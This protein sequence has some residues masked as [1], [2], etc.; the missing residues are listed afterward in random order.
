MKTLPHPSPDRPAVV[1]A[2]DVPRCLAMVR[3]APRIVVP[4][5]TP[6]E[7][8]HAPFKIMTTLH[9]C[10]EHKNT[11]RASLYWTDAN[12]RKAEIIAKQ[13]RPAGFRLDFEAAR[14]ELLLVTTP[15]YR[16]FM[17]GLGVNCV[18]C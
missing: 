9:Y 4:S 15:E 17:R 7:P 8:G 18:A 11:F 13:I 16:D 12:K 3:R 2:C 14:V 5:M 10:D 1:M 6:D